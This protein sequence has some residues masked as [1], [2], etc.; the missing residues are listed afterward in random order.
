MG[1]TSNELNSC[2]SPIGQLYQLASVVLVY[3]EWYQAAAA[4]AQ[5]VK[6]PFIKVPQRGANVS[7]IPGRGI[8]V[9]EKILARPSEGVK[10]K[11]DLQIGAK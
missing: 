1:N 5:A 7:L 4:V 11:T 9:R 8:G 2:P 10:G 3:Q 6:R